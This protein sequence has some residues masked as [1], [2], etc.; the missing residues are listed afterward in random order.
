M[1]QVFVLEV[2]TNFNDFRGKRFI[3]GNDIVN[4]YAPG[5]FRLIQIGFQ[6]LE[7]CRWCDGQDLFFPDLPGDVQPRNRFIEVKN[8]LLVFFGSDLLQELLN[9]GRH[10]SY[11][12]LVVA[13]L[14]LYQ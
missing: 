9:F 11:L 14:V 13:P 12:D 2:G 8:N 3:A 1:S 5:K 6:L 10:D 4:C 7:T